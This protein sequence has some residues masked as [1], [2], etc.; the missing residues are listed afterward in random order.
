MADFFKVARNPKGLRSRN[1]NKYKEYVAGVLFVMPVVL[2]IIIFVMYPMVYSLI[3]SFT[4]FNILQPPKFIGI[5]NYI[6]IFAAD[7]YFK[8]SALVTIYYAF[9][10]VIATLITAFLV[11]LLLN[12][13]IR[14]RSVLRT[15]FYLPTIV[16]AV[17]SSILWLWL[18][19]PD[20]GLLNMVLSLVNIP[21]QMWIF[22]ESTVIPSLIMMA[23]WGCGNTVVIF[24]AGLQD[25]PRQLIEAVK[26]DGG[27]WWH[28]FCF[29]TIPMVTPIIFFN[30][31]MSLINAFQTFTQAYIMTNG[32]P[33]NDS[34]FYAYLIYRD[35]FQ[36][37]NM[38]YASALSWILFLIISIFTVILFSTSN[39]WVYYGGGENS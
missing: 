21:K 16:P 3:L 38:G 27:N 19:N 18:F 33:N 31:I 35:A 9:G 23:V 15:I 5:K 36:E 17:A 6:T 26:I 34:L 24:L 1:K 10:S 8:K 14:G 20:F 22:G 37:N 39:K 28:E 7:L 29:V 25:V 32:G 2:G 13:D 12:Q 11:A 30:L 4:N